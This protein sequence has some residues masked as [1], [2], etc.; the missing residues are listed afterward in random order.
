MY[1]PTIYS[2]LPEHQTNVQL[3]F[4]AASVPSAAAARLG[5]QVLLEKTSRARRSWALVAV[6]R[7]ASPA[8]AGLPNHAPA[9]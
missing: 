1:Q 5:H 9:R 2:H 4:A 8:R 6:R 3:P 7:L